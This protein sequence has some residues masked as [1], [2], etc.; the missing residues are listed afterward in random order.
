MAVG[1]GTISVELLL[2]DR[3]LNSG[4]K[5]KS[6]NEKNKD[7]EREQDKKEVRVPVGGYILFFCHVWLKNLN[8]RQCVLSFSSHWHQTIDIFMNLKIIKFKW[9]EE[10][11]YPSGVVELKENR[12]LQ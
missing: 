6:R 7:G 3:K 10:K 8:G 5:V 9:T 12:G 2:R 1:P 4:W 11:D